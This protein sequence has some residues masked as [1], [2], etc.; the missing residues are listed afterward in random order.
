[1][2]IVFVA[3]TGTDVGKTWW[4]AS[5]LR[6]ERAAGTAVTARKP[7]QSFAPGGGDTDADVLAAAAGATPEQ[8][9][10]PHR[11]YERPL[12]PPMAAAALARP[13]FT[14]A[15]LA[16]ETTAAMPH[17]ATFVLVEGAGGPR[18]P[19]AAD[20]DNID[21]ATALQ[22]DLIVLVAD[23]GLGAINAVRLSAAPFSECL[24]DTELVVALNRF[25]PDHPHEANRAWL[26]ERDGFTV[27]IDPAELVGLGRDDA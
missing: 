19:I 8:V 10:P 24:A 14:I 2:T 7:V 5:W 11:W 15:E 22:P 9:C 20:G 17:E 23:A 1:M 25:G 26:V 13:T 4:A 6:A 3:G 16:V 18:S 27:V 21:L 12:A